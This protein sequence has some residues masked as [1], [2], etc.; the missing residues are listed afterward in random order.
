MLM[1]TGVVKHSFLQKML[2]Q[3]NCMHAM[4]C[5]SGLLQGAFMLPADHSAARIHG[6]SQQEG[7]R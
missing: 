3:L 1:A 2:E 5:K 7:K 6:C 4:Q